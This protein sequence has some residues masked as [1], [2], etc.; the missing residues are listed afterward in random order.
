M[1]LKIL[2]SSNGMLSGTSDCVCN[3]IRRRYSVVYVLNKWLNFIGTRLE[4]EVKPPYANIC[5]VGDPV[6]RTKCEAIKLETVMEP[7]FEKIISH[8]RK[9]MRKHG[10]ISLSAPQ[11]GLP[12]ELFTLEVTHRFLKK[13]KEHEIQFNEI[14]EVPF[15]VFINPKLKIL[16]YNVVIREETCRSIYGYSADVPRAKEVEVT[17]LNSEGNLESL[18]AKGFTSRIIQHEYD[19]LKGKLFIDRMD[20]TTFQNKIWYEINQKKGKCKLNYK[21]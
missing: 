3:K 21:S 2:E 4:G 10:T 9:V 12:L 15:K 19:H 18:K 5:Q 7:K 6:L 8:M 13:L 11:I 14:E 20:V 17:F 1:L 16:D